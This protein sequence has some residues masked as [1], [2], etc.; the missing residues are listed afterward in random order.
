[1]W[2]SVKSS[3]KLV[4]SLAKFNAEARKIMGLD[5]YDQCQKKKPNG[6]LDDLDDEWDPV[7]PPDILPKTV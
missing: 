3:G 2:G 1:M 5:A 7:D 6:S 4:K